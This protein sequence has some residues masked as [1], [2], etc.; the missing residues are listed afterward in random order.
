[1]ASFRNPRFTFEVAPIEIGDGVERPDRCHL[2]AVHDLA[3][4]RRQFGME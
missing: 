3:R 1:M 4:G 2:Q